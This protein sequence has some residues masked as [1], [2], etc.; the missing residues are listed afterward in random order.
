MLAGLMALTRDMDRW[1]LCLAWALAGCETGQLFGTE[2]RRK[3]Y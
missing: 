2:M 1:L 3:S